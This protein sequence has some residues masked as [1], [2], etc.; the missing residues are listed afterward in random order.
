MPVHYDAKNDTYHGAK[1]LDTYVENIRKI[2]KQQG[3]EL[4]DEMIK[5]FLTQAM[6]WAVERYIDIGLDLEE[7]FDEVLQLLKQGLHEYRNMFSENEIRRII[8]AESGWQN[9]AKAKGQEYKYFSKGRNEG[10]WHED[11]VEESVFGRTL[12]QALR[13]NSEFRDVENIFTDEKPDP[14]RLRTRGREL[15]SYIKTWAD[16][17]AFGFGIENLDRATGG[18]LPGEICVLTGAPGTMKTS[19]ALSAV[20][21]FVTRKAQGRILFISADMPPRE[22]ELRMLERESG[23]PNFQLRQ[24]FADDDPQAAKIEDFVNEKYEDKLEVLGNDDGI[25]LNLQNVLIECKARQPQL[26]IIDYLTRLKSSGQSDL[27]FVE[28]AMKAILAHAHRY[29]TSFLLLSQMSRASR[30]EQATGRMGGHSRG[31]GIVEELSDCEIELVQQA[32]EFEGEK[33]LVIACV[34]KARRGIAGQYFSLDYDGPIKRFTGY[35]QRAE[36]QIQRKA[37]FRV[38]QERSFY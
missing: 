34:T 11:F 23:V 29:E 26:V 27:E 12:R 22:I 31:G 25:E 16:F 32:S 36:R 19:L 15:K 14:A 18:I 7:K 35:A 28:K 33:P 24:M 21:D 1:E 8:G 37:I 13:D 30:S 3:S 17:P 20:D 9:M 38:A 6:H 2:Q 5:T 4:D 10:K